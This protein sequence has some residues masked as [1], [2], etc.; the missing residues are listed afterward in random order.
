MERPLAGLRVLEIG[1][2]LAGPF[3]PSLLA[4]F[5][6]EVI[7]VEMPGEGDMVRQ[8]LPLYQ[9]KALRWEVEARNKKVITLDFHAEE[10]RETFKQLVAVSDAIVENFRAGTLERWGLGYPELSQR[11]PGIVITRVTGFG[12]DGPYSHRVSYDRMGIAMGGLTYLSGDPDRIPVRPGLAICDYI[13]GAFN[14]LATLVALYYR[15]GKGGGRG[16]WID[17][18]Q[19]ETIYRITGFLTTEY[20]L[21][22]RIREREGNRYPKVAPGESYRTREGKW[23]HL[24]VPS[25]EELSRLARAMG[26]EDLL[27]DPRFHTARR[28]AEHG[29]EINDMVAQWMAE[30]TLPEI[31]SILEE[32]RLPF[33]LIYNLQEIFEDPHYR[34][35]RTLISLPDTALGELQMQGVVPR[36]SL[37]PGRVERPAPG[38][39]GQDNEEVFSRLFQGLM[40]RP[41]AKSAPASS[42]E[43]REGEA[44]Q[45][46]RVLDLGT[47]LAGNFGAVLLADY[48]AEVI[49]VEEPRGSQNIRHI[50]PYYEEAP[51][52]WA[53]DGRNKRSITLDLSQEQGEALFKQLVRV[54]DLVIESYPPGTLEA[55][56]LGCERLREINPGLILVHVTGFGQE[57]PYRQRPWSDRVAEAMSGLTYLTGYPDRPPTSLGLPVTEYVT[58]VF[59][60]LGAML[61]LYYRDAKR[62][63]RGQCVDVALYEAIF[64]IQG[65]TAVEYSKTGIVSERTGNRNPSAPLDDIYRCADG[66]L[67]AILAAGDRM[68]VRAMKAIGREDLLSD[69]RFRDRAGRARPEHNALIH[70]V[71]EEWI[72]PRPLGEV[73]EVLDRGEVPYCKVYSI[74]D[75]CEDLHYQA[76]EIIA[77]VKDPTL[78]EI[79]MQGI[80][81]RFSLT[82]GRIERGAPALGQDNGE[83]YGGLLGLSEGEIRRLKETGII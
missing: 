55:Y 11:N 33:S 40:E 34:A 13:T 8:T 60:A 57:G 49:K 39:I 52:L 31:L 32:A 81:P 61:A 73:E 54:S 41:P 51:L 56:N 67:I 4:D 29:A 21:R 30:H 6:A 14:A 58:G 1:S 26:R 46:L 82:P 62:T 12:Q 5:G 9:G 71:M 23:V 15:D 17:V 59:S 16:Q 18:A 28:R 2:A 69:P 38:S 19:Y 53:V 78:G 80:V 44:L 63:G 50:P 48:G 74:Q 76:R 27:E 68:F 64:R 66:K 22:G 24:F 25:D 45:G 72:T 43:V 42:E 47:G 37:T 7:K 3:G 20:Q 10:D 75:I 65:P 70:K 36:L 35:R 83:I 79:R 77:Q